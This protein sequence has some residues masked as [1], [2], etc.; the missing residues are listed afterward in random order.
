M[1]TVRR[2]LDDPRNTVL[3]SGR[4]VQQ[5]CGDRAPY[6]DT[7]RLHDNEDAFDDALRN[8][9]AYKVS[10]PLWVQDDTGASDHNVNVVTY[11]A[12][13]RAISDNGLQKGYVRVEGPGSGYKPDFL[14]PEQWMDWQG[15]E[16]S[17]DPRGVKLES[18][19]FSTSLPNPPRWRRTRVRTDKMRW[20][21]GVGG[22]GGTDWLFL[23]CPKCETAL[24]SAWSNTLDVLPAVGRGVAMAVSYVPV[25]GTAI[26]FVITAGIALAE[27]RPLDDAMLQAIGA[28][29]PGQP[30]SGIAFN[31]GVAIAK[32]KRIDEIAI[33]S[34][35]LPPQLKSLTQ[36]AANVVYGLASGENVSSVA[37][38]EIRKKLSPE[39]QK[40]LDLAKRV[41]DG[42]NVPGLLLSEAEKAV[43]TQVRAQAQS[44]LDQARSQGQA[45]LGIA[46]A[47]AD[48]LLN[49]YAAQT[50]YQ[51]ALMQLST[52]ERDALSTGLTAGAASHPTSSEGTFG[53]VPEK[54]AA[55]MT[56]DAWFQKGLGIVQGGATYKGLR[57]ADMLSG[58]V[59]FQVELWEPDLF[60]KSWK[61]QTQVYHV[62]PG[63][64]GDAFR[65]G[66]L[67]AT[68]NCDGLTEPPTPSSTSSP[69]KR[70]EQLAVYQSLAERGGRPGF[71]AG[72]AVAYSRTRS[73]ADF[74][75]I[76]EIHLPSGTSAAKL[77][78]D[79]QAP[80]STLRPG[81]GLPSL[82][83]ALP[84]SSFP[85]PP[86][87]PT[88]ST[89]PATVSPQA[90]AQKASD[91]AKWVDYYTKL[92]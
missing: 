54:P 19:M 41:I 82:T 1:S 92:V 26:S 80:A 75:I 28:A 40:A 44:L 35:P 30:V 3:Q 15:V 17:A 8:R 58:A 74:K 9:T 37:L 2:L 32:G 73:P 91:R 29:L 12:N 45:A 61:K 89:V 18:G 47:Q 34:L 20:G 10:D 25:F 63:P 85:P 60:S 31:A 83:I 13:G 90:L 66:F 27:D 52:A 36:V 62:L 70:P 33:A 64:D 67:I 87:A 21:Q 5:C 55:K 86:P 56:N 59:S 77:L 53:S 51:T 76:S 79:A 72:E 69:K 84:A 50:G 78:G 57:L 65:R 43:V 88:P 48:G 39:G 4:P 16:W 46:Q 7:Y 14:S 71:D 68:G 11:D 24:E 42:E 22:W 81:V 38:S 23:W 6:W 49:S